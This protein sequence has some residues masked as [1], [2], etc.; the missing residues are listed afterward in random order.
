MTALNGWQ[1]HTGLGDN[2]REIITRM[3]DGEVF[4]TGESGTSLMYYDDTYENPFRW[5]ADPQARSKPLDQAW[6]CIGQ[7]VSVDQYTLCWVNTVHSMAVNIKDYNP[8]N[9]RHESANNG[10]WKYAAPVQC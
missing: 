7:A 4:Y 1:K 3:M 9:T 10:W 8:D 2:M 6:A 5:L